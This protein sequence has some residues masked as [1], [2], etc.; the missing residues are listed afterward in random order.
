[1]KMI[2]EAASEDSYFIFVKSAATI[3]HMAK[4]EE[5][6]IIHPNKTNWTRIFYGFQ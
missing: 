3:L 2:L 5:V 1:M 6:L 4:L